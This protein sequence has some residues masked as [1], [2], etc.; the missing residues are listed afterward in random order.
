MSIIAVNLSVLTRARWSEYAS[1]FIFGGATTA[2]AGI[3]AKEYG[4]TIG[5][6][7]LAFPAIFPATATLIENHEKRK[8]RQA[9]GRGTIRGRKAAALD[10]AGASL[11]AFGLMTFAV[12]VW[13]LLS[14]LSPW[15]TLPIATLGWLVVSFLAWK[16]W[17]FR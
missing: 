7:F 8:K 17:R 14:H 5:G 3:I 15:A 4:P 6:L 12:L 1:R 11:G 9:G 10:A 2:L 13:R 16:L